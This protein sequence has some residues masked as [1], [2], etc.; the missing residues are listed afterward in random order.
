MVKKQ[1]IAVSSAISRSYS[2]E[3]APSR[4]RVAGARLVDT[5]HHQRVACCRFTL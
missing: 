2:M 5:F 1:G 4:S 3:R